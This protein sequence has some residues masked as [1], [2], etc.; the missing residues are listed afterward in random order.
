MVKRNLLRLLCMR[1]LLALFT[2]LVSLMVSSC[3]SY[4]SDPRFEGDV[5]S[6]AALLMAG[7]PINQNWPVYITKSAALEDLNLLDLFVMNADVKIIEVP[8]GREFPLQ[9]VIDYDEYNVKW[10]D[11]QANII[12]PMQRYRI[13]VRIPDKEELISAETVVPPLARLEPDYFGHNVPGEG[14][15]INLAD[16]PQMAYSTSD[17]R[18]PL[19]LDMGE[20]GGVY[21]LIAELYCMEEF[22]TDLEY[23]TK[24]LGMSH[25]TADMES[26]YNSSGEGLRRIRFIG[27]FSAEGQTET[28]SNYILLRNY[29]QG[30][31]FYG[32]YS[33]SMIVSDDNYYRYNYM[34]EGYLHGGV[35]NG[36]GYFGSASGGVMY[37][38]V[39]K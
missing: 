12:K 24:I 21:N 7:Q 14:F 31:I 25:P 6:V 32:R 16:I 34:P 4:T 36:L 19:A 1:G 18:Y 13:E 35:Q 5:Y 29:R 39:V 27:R 22:S 23:T 28:Q 30:F 26:A 37:T 15:G 8:G 10:I 11:P 9:P 38:E 2:I 20:N 17:I 33:V 3:D